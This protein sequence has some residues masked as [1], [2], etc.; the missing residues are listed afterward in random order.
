TEDGATA[1]VDD[2]VVT[3]A[4]GRPRSV[5]DSPVPVDVFTSEDL[6]QVAQTDTLNTLQTLIPSF[7]VSRSNNTTSN[8]F[9]RSPTLR[10]LPAN[11]TLL[12]V[13]GRRRHKSASVGVNGAGSQ[14]ADAS[15]IPS[16][17]LS[18]A[19][20]LRDGAAA[21]YGSDAIAGVINFVLKNA[22]HGG[23]LMAQAGQHYEGDGDDY[24]VAGNIGLPLTENGFINLSAQWTRNARTVRANQFTTTGFDAISYAATHPEYAAL[25]DLSEPL[26]RTGRP[27][28]E[29]LRFVVNSGLDLT[30][31]TSLYAFGNYSQS[32]GIA[33]ANYRYPGGGQPVLD[34][35]IRL[36]DGSVFRFNSL[37]PGGLRPQ[38]AGEVTDWSVAGGVRDRRVFSNGMTFDSDI[39]L[40]YGWDKI[41][42]SIIDTLNPSLGP[43]SQQNFRASNYAS[44]EF[45]VN[46][47]FALG[48]PVA[49]F[50]SPLV[51]SF[52]GEY[53]REGF[54]IRPGEEASYTAG[55]FSA[56]DPYD[57]CTNEA[58]V[59][60]RTLRSTAPQ[61]QGI[62]CAL[63]SDPIY[64]T[65][66]V[67]SNGITGLPPANTGEYE[68]ASYSLYVEA[69]TDITDKWYVDFAGRFEDYE[70]FGS[71]FI[72]K[73]ATR[74]ELFDGFAIR[75][76]AGT[77]FRAPT[78]GQVKMTQ[79][80]IN[81]VN[82]VAT[83]TGLYPAT[84]PVAV[85]LGAKPLKPEESTNYSIGITAKPFPGFDLTIDAYQIEV[86]DQVY[87]TAALT[88][89][90]AIRAQMIAA[91]IPGAD[92]IASIN[93]FQNA[94]DA[95]VSGIDVVGSY[96]RRWDDGSSSGLVGSFNYN[97]YEIGEIK[98]A[99]LFNAQ[100][101][102]NFENNQPEWRASLTA[103]H[104]VGKWGLM[105]RAN[106]YGPYAR[107]ATAGTFAIQEYDPEVMFDAEV[108]YDINDNYKLAVGGRN[109]FDQYPDPNY[110]NAT[111]GRL[112]ADGAVDWQGGFYYARL[113]YAF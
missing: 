72:G 76:S 66:A 15:V 90:P 21:Q 27:K 88:V 113:T 38:F 42:Y 102:F 78:A 57:Y 112:Y 77:G 96:R 8:T 12:L 19:E 65:L 86:Q 6:A 80:G 100:S 46:G 93:F 24:L 34:N 18:S 37:Y 67:G 89:T 26:E 40:R 49:A 25:V 73:V 9:I 35:P 59:T 53:R 85:F 107:Q 70:D 30:N 95:T 55:R 23:S 16:I 61:N 22:N 110:I 106:I 52:G 71:T 43:T 68:S 101:V 63:A 105:S 109:V 83:N 99:G 84:N 51:L 45:A 98:I 87:S 3:G 11:N 36:Q 32:K 54:E 31:E 92:T 97:K 7:S 56:P 75:A 47:D 17:A 13:N 5:Q 29:A 111:N 62:N 39:G 60:S 48:V 10:G 69:T 104:N 74:Y 79:V 20:V 82:G 91:N 33:A 2:V 64:N 81:T 4:R 58:L 50:E 108:T 14:A 103:T 94:F 1:A 41:D 44:N 28:E